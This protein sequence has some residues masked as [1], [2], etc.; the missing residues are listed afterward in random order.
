MFND[1]LETKEKYKLRERKR[2]TISTFTTMSSVC[3]C[4]MVKFTLAICIARGSKVRGVDE[5]VATAFSTKVLSGSVC[6]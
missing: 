2:E 5:E 1:L 3:P 4:V 6:G